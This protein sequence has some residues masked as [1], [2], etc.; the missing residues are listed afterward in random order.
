MG[1]IKIVSGTMCVNTAIGRAVRNGLNKAIVAFGSKPQ[2]D[3]TKGNDSH[4]FILAEIWVYGNLI[5]GKVT[6]TFCAT[7][8]FVTVLC[9]SPDQMLMYFRIVFQ[10]TRPHSQKKDLP[11]CRK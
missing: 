1:K 4:T 9:K 6:V 11:F 5:L 7:S 2:H 10:L 8:L 3:F